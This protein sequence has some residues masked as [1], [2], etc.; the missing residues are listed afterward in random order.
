MKKIITILFISI[1]LIS[2]ASVSLAYPDPANK[3]SLPYDSTF[4]FKQSVTTKYCYV[5]D[6]G[7]L[8]LDISDIKMEN[9]KSA[10]LNAQSCYYISSTGKWG[11]GGTQ[12]V[13]I[14]NGSAADTT[15]SYNVVSGRT[16][17]MRF[18]KSDYTS[19]KVS[20]SFSIY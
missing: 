8:D 5:P 2:I 20:A 4:S 13:S 12:K 17:C 18:S 6:S 7:S 16:Y 19:L 3:T 10:T 11:S 14:T 15:K 1:L 9:S